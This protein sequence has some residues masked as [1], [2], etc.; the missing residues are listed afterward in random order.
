M[1]AARIGACGLAK[2][3]IGAIMLRKTVAPMAAHLG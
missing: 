3:E 1:T 2:V